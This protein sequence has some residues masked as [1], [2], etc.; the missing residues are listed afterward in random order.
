MTV[1]ICVTISASTNQSHSF[2]KIHYLLPACYTGL[3]IGSSDDYLQGS[4]TFKGSLD[5]PDLV[6]CR[7]YDNESEVIE[8]TEIAEGHTAI[9]G[10]H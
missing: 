9:E 5:L 8:E 10:M 1:R 7:W 2:T 6:W 4:T 3:L